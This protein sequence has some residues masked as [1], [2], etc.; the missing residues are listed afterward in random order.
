MAYQC[1]DGHRI[2]KGYNETF[3]SAFLQKL[4][5]LWTIAKASPSAS[6]LPFDI[7]MKQALPWW[8]T[9][10]LPV[11]YQEFRIDHVISPTYHEIFKKCC[12][13]FSCEHDNL[14]V[15]YTLPIN[16]EPGTPDALNHWNTKSEEWDEVVKES[17]FEIYQ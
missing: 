17:L 8:I 2:P 12:L 4:D 6:Q 13:A 1:N 10:E 9:H 14:G 5:N 3:K 16:I 7:F 11:E 15:V